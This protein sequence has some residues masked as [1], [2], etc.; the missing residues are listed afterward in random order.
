MP[1]ICLSRHS[2]SGRGKLPRTRQTIDGDAP[3]KGTHGAWPVVRK[4]SILTM[5]DAI[6]PP[7]NLSQFVAAQKPAK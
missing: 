5:L 7:L 2:R 6:L 3:R 1:L 4:N